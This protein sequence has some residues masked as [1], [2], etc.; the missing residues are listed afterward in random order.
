V[1]ELRAFVEIDA[2]QPQWAAYVA[3]TCQGDPPSAGMAQLYVEVVPANLVFSLVDAAVKNAAVRA[4]LQAVERQFGTLEVHGRDPSDVKE[5]GAAILERL[6]VSAAS[7]AAPEVIAT[8][9]V[10]RVGPNQ[11]Q[12]VNRLRVANLLLEDETMFLLEAAPAANVA[13]AANEAEKRSPVKLVYAAI[14]GA[15]GRLIVSGRDDAIAEAR[16]AALAAV[17]SDV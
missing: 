9:V 15:S 10:T 16:Q 4:G 12:L 3:Q 2:M 14:L 8:E 17:G 6:G 1:P 5:A 11:A 7:Q 13:L